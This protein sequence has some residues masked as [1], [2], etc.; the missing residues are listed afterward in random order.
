MTYLYNRR[1]HDNQY[2]I[3]KDGGMLVIGNSAVNVD[4]SNDITINA[5]RFKWQS[6]CGSYWLANTEYCRDHY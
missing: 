5:K 6:D 2:G 1:F 3:R 4:E